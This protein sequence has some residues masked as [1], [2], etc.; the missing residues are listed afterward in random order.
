M[1]KVWR[2]SSNFLAESL[3]L[4]SKV[5]LTDQLLHS[6]VTIP[7][8]VMFSDEKPNLARPATSC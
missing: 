7:L 5:I 8:V 1:V 3:N 4:N 2:H 6:P